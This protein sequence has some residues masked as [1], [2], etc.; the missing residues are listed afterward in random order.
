MWVD[1][2][3]C[4]GDIPAAL[5]AA[6]RQAMLH[7]MRGSSKQHKRDMAALI[8]N[9]DPVTRAKAMRDASSRRFRVRALSQSLPTYPHEWQKVQGDNEY[10]RMYDTHI[11]GGICPCSMQVPETMEHI[12]ME[13]PFTAG[14]RKQAQGDIHKIWGAARGGV[15]RWLELDWI[16]PHPDVGASNS[17]EFASAP[18]PEP[19]PRPNPNLARSVP[20]TRGNSRAH[21]K[22]GGGGSDWS[23]SN[24]SK[25]SLRVT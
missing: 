2:R 23:L 25:T 12:F 24:S 14:V 16:D 17:G 5:K 11:A 1:G 20:P 4:E 6:A 21:G 13:C 19:R 3:M 7:E 22:G 15:G 18:D 10:A 9:S 8:N